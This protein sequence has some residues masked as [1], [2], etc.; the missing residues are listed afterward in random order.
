MPFVTRPGVVQQV[1]KYF[2]GMRVQ[3]VEAVGHENSALDFVD[4]VYPEES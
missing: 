3:P 2:L 1:L 4:I